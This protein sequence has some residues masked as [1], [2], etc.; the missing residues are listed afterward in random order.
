DQ[1]DR[2]IESGFQDLKNLMNLIQDMVHISKS[3]KEKLREK[4]NEI[5]SDETVLFKSYLLSLG[6][7]QD[8]EDPVKRSKYNS[9]NKYYNELAKQLSKVIK[10]LAKSKGGQIALTEVYC[11]INRARGFDLISPDDLLNA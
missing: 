1:T 6:V 9:D 4:G 5:S 2:N 10:P 11:A 8:F 3:I 7:N